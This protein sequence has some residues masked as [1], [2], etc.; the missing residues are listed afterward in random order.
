[1]RNPVQKGLTWAVVLV[2]VLVT[3][4]L[5]SRDDP[6]TG[7]ARADAP[8]ASV[9]AKPAPAPEP[10]TRPAA[11]PEETDKWSRVA[12]VVEDRREREI[13]LETLALI[14][15]GGPFPYPK[16]DGSVFSNRERRLPAKARGYY[17]EY[18]VPTPGAN[19]RGARRVVQGREG[20]TYYTDDHYRTFVRIDQ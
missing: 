3:A 14:D 11:A 5:Q 10:E 13:L 16:K 1:M 19:N 18:T 7:A 9:P 2:A 12:D 20:E 17:R 15:A 4:M 8:A 6:K